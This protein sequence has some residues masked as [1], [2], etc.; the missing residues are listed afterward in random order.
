[1]ILCHCNKVPVGDLGSAWS[2]Q[3]VPLLNQWPCPSQV[4]LIVVEPAVN[5]AT[6]IVVK[7]KWHLADLSEAK[8][9]FVCVIEGPLRFVRTLLC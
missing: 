5:L 7:P 9:V 4:V 3:P 1:M 2:S 6:I 8:D